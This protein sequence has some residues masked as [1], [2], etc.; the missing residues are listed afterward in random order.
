GHQRAGRHAGAEGARRAE[1]PI[2]GWLARVVW[3]G[4]RCHIWLIPRCDGQERSAN[5]LEATMSIA[6]AYDVP[7]AWRNGGS[8]LGKVE[9]TKRQHKE[10][11]AALPLR[12]HRATPE[13]GAEQTASQEI[14]DAI[15]ALYLSGNKPRDRQIADRITALYRDAIAEDE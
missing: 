14:F 5:R 6:H 2:P 7:M 3:S 12:L 11:A 9:V 8:D 13:I 10:R 4:S 1:R 15:E